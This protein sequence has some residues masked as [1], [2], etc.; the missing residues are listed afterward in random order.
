M[1]WVINSV[2]NSGCLCAH[3]NQKSCRTT[4]TTDVPVR[5]TTINF[6]PPVVKLGP[7]DPSHY[8]LPCSKYGQPKTIGQPSGCP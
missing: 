4:K 7:D 2:Q 8:C 6:H 3:D 5:W 1:K